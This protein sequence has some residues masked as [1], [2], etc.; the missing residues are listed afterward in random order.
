VK[1][2]RC[3][4]VR[5][6]GGSGDA[7]KKKGKKQ[8]RARVWQVKK[9]GKQGGL[10]LLVPRSRREGGIRHAHRGIAAAAETP[11]CGAGSRWKTWRSGGTPAAEG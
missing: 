7:G 1:R 8:P 2:L 3:T 9:R 11:A 10:E 4:P 5:S 6:A